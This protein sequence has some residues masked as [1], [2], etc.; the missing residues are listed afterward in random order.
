M[1]RSRE[2]GREVGLTLRPS[3][4]E[5]GVGPLHE[6]VQEIDSALSGIPI[7]TIHHLSLNQI[8]DEHRRSLLFMHHHLSCSVGTENALL[9]YDVNVWSKNKNGD[10]TRGPVSITGAMSVCPEKD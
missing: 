4:R 3:A 10:G 6:L 1:V 5:T 7:Q 9:R 8:G 2:V